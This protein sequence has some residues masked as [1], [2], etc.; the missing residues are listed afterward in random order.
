[1]RVMKRSRLT[2]IGTS[3]LAGL[4]VIALAGVSAGAPGGDES[5]GAQ[6]GKPAPA[7]TLS[8]QDGK[9][10]S[11]SD[12]KGKIVVI[13]WFNGECPFVKAQHTNGTLK[14]FPAMAMKEGV[15][16]LAIN[17]SAPGLQGSGLDKN[18]MF[19]KE[20]GM[21]YPMLFD[22]S[23]EV[24]HL[25]GAK[26]TPHMFVID[27]AGTLVYQG[28]IDNAPMGKVEGGGEKTNY[29]GKALASVAK[30]EPVAE[31]K[32][33]PYG[34]SVKYAKMAGGEKKM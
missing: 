2:G 5:S 23:G 24:G 29:V 3:F 21:P 6:L 25:Y 32:T 9:K 10:L 17:S 7:F 18:T 12:F 11:L 30:G 19:R 16:W 22:E 26:T 34:C 27:K 14:E 13:E 4:A 31:S 33:T 15:V 1:M 28:A 8:D 20:Y